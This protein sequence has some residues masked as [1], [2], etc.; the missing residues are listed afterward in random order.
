MF[1]MNAT[2][3]QRT[4]IVVAALLGHSRLARCEEPSKT[5]DQMFQ[6]GRAALAEEDYESAR[7]YFERSYKVDPALGTLLN[8]AVCEEKL[9]KLRAALAHLQEA[10][11][12][13]EPDDRRRPLIAQRLARLDSRVPRLTIRPSRPLDSSVT[14]S[15]DAKSLGAAEIGTTL[16]LD[17]GTHVLDCA[18]SRGERCTIVFTLEEGQQSVQ[19]PT[20][21]APAASAPAAV[22]PSPPLF[23]RVPAQPAPP[24]NGRTHSGQRS[25]AYAAGGFGLASV[26]VGLIAGAAVIQQKNLVAAHC[27]ER[28]CDEDGIAAAQRG[29]TLSTVST[30]ATGMGV[31]VMG[32]SL[33]VLI[34][35][36]SAKD[37]ATGL[38]LAGSF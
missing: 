17:P 15:L 34:T 10:M 21:S 18:G 36:P 6:E 25:F 2:R 13:A 1:S 32:A 31:V 26:A 9:G 19:V 27:D 8:L 30:I 14:L 22:A 28:G 33:Y 20:L 3:S 24:P 29:K 5:A 12:K 16:R 38:S 11:D 4:A 7:S 35:A 37:S 23:E